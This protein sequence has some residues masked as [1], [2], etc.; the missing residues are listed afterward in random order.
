M[1]R[2]ERTNEELA[3]FVKAGDRSAAHAL[4]AN[5]QNLIQ[6]IARRYRTVHREALERAGQ[7]GCDLEQEGYFAMLEAAGAF[8]ESKG[9]RFNTYLTFHAWNRFGRLC[10]LRGRREALNDAVSLDASFGEYEDN[11]GLMELIADPDAAEEL[12]R[13]AETDEEKEIARVVSESVECLPEAER[14]VIRMRYYSG[15]EYTSIMAETGEPVRRIRRIHD[16]ALAHLAENEGIREAAEKM[17]IIERYAYGGTLARFRSTFT[18][19]VET[20]V[21]EMERRKLL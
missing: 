15:L 7:E 1:I 4:W 21:L 14:N 17:G 10:G 8:E 16:R 20:A 18:S 19:T 11:E 2:L 5:C 6:C 13:I 3:L 12:S 9:Y